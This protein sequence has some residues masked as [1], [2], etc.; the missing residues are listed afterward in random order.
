VSIEQ[1]LEKLNELE[2]KIKFLESQLAASNARVAEL[3]AKLAAKDKDSNN[4]SNPPSKDPPGTQR[5][6][7]KRKKTD[8]KPGGQK[9]HQGKSKNFEKEPDIVQTHEATSCL[10]CG[11]SLEG[12]EGKVVE[13]RQEIDIPPIE[14]IIT[15]HQLIEKTCPCCKHRSRGS[16]PDHIR[17]LI[18]FGLNTIIAVIYFNVVHHIPFQ[19][20]TKIFKDMFHMSISEGTVENILNLAETKAIKYYDQI[21]ELLQQ[22]KWVGSDETSIRINGQTWWRWVW[23]ND[24]LTYFVSVSSRAYQVVKDFFGESFQGILLHDCYGAQL[25]T[26]A[27]EHQLCLAHLIRELLFLI[28]FEKSMWAFKMIRFF[29][30]VIKA[31]EIIWSD[32]FDLIKRE[33]VIRDCFR[34]LDKLLD[35]MPIKKES[36]KIWKRL[37]KHKDKLLT[38]LVHQDVPA[39]NNGSERAI[40]NAKIHRKISG[41]FRGDHAPQR[42]SIL[43]SVIETAKKQGYDLLDSCKLMLN[44]QLVLQA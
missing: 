3:E 25:A 43:L 28:D 42:H 34:E 21:K 18:Q 9:G 23:Q 19:R 30:K 17:S 24:K 29:S 31:K 1:L 33:K 15:E 16:F 44:Q 20:T 37:R 26:V 13:R 38:F 10:E 7:P 11:E 14:P 2:A 4:S 22:S 40:R 5:K 8:K 41:C 12:V 32:G 6:Y 36:H 39:T 35:L 27:S